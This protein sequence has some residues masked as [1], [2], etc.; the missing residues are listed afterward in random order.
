MFSFCFLLAHYLLRL[1]AKQ[2]GVSKEGSCLS[3]FLDLSA[4]LKHKNWSI[5]A[6]EIIAACLVELYSQILIT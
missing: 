3:E 2:F 5:F 4:F 6:L 1:K